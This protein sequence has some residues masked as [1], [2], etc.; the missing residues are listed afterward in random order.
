MTQFQ[1][2][3]NLIAARGKMTQSEVAAKCGVEQQTY[4]HWE[5][6]RTRP[7]IEKMLLLEKVLGVP[8]EELFSDIFNSFNELS[9]ASDKAV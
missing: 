5:T 4:S 2:R 6:G 9:A 1:K 8:K 3:K 7:S